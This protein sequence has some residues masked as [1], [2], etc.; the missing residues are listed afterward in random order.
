MPK[1]RRW[2]GHSFSSEHALWDIVHSL[3]HYGELVGPFSHRPLWLTR[4]LFFLHIIHHKE[5]LSVTKKVH[6]RNPEAGDRRSVHFW[7]SQKSRGYT[8]TQISSAK[9]N[10]YRLLS[11]WPWSSWTEQLL[12]EGLHCDYFN[13]SSSHKSNCR[14]L[15]NNFFF[16]IQ[17]SNIGLISSHYSAT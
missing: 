13:V 1:G 7:A 14:F 11:N 2:Q 12:L 10:A 9:F 17:V 3:L 6:P 8:S 15:W 4:I 16:S 5:P